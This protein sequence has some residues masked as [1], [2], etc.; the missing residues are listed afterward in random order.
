MLPCMLPHHAALRCVRTRAG[1]RYYENN[2]LDYGGWRTWRGWR[3]AGAH[4][5][6]R[7]R[8]VHTHGGGMRA[9]VHAAHVCACAPTRPHARH[10]DR[11]R[12]VLY[13]DTFDYTPSQ[14]SPEWHGWLNYINDYNPK[15]RARPCACAHPCGTRANWVAQGTHQH[16]PTSTQHP[17]PVQPSSPAAHMPLHARS[18]HPPTPQNHQFSQPIYKVE[19]HATKTGSDE[20]YQPKGA[21]AQPRKRSWIKY[22]AWAPPQ[23]QQKA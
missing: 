5:A 19:A 7:P 10:A 20:A 2:N 1:N 4:C 17:R 11:K 18:T 22:E 8:M 14:I 3:G 15:V 9:R 16:C 23:Q 6:R 13:K 21:W 12:W